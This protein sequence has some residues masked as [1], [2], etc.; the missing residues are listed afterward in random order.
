[1][2]NPQCHF[3]KYV[4]VVEHAPNC[5]TSNYL[6]TQSYAAGGSS[7]K[8]GDFS[9]IPNR[10]YITI[11]ELLEGL[12]ASSCDGQIQALQNAWFAWVQTPAA[13]GENCLPMDHRK[14]W[15]F[16]VPDST[17]FYHMETGHH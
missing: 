14:G 2:D 13:Q 8:I 10:E 12:N 1:M 9:P 11:F 4:A 17:V 15:T 7:I 6:F 16:V 5:Q 3:V